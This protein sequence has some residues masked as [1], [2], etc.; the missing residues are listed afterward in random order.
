[1]KPGPMVEAA[2]SAAKAAEEERQKRE[3]P[4]KKPAPKLTGEML[5]SW[6]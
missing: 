5:R 3:E 4:V 2:A 1:M 6:A